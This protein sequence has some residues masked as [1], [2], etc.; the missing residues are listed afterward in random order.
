MKRDLASS[1]CRQL[2]GQREWKYPSSGL[3]NSLLTLS[4]SEYP[5]RGHGIR[6]FLAFGLPPK[7]DGLW[8]KARQCCNCDFS[9][10]PNWI[11]QESYF[12]DVDYFIRNVQNLNVPRANLNIRTWPTRAWKIFN[13]HSK[14]R[15]IHF[16]I[17][18]WI[19]CIYFR[20]ISQKNKTSKRMNFSGF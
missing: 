10:V 2:C 1:V 16:Q 13:L 12:W 17:V 18:T 8:H 3:H 11:M 5:P 15:N 20:F 6:R 19:L 9:I 14:Q 4:A 7:I